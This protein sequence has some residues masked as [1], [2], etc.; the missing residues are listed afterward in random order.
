[1]ENNIPV[2]NESY[3]EEENRILHEYI[4]SASDAELVNLID[5][6]C[7]L[8]AEENKIAVKKAL[9]DFAMEIQ[10]RAAMKQKYD[11]LCRCRDEWKKYIH[12]MEDYI[13]AVRIREKYSLYKEKHENG[14]KTSFNDFYCY[15]KDETGFAGHTYEFVRICTFS[16]ESKN[17]I[18]KPEQPE[19]SYDSL[20]D[21]PIENRLDFNGS[22]EKLGTENLRC[23]LSRITASFGDSRNERAT[24]A[25]IRFMTRKYSFGSHKKKTSVPLF[26]SVIPDYLS[27][28]K[29]CSEVLAEI[30]ELKADAQGIEN[31][32][33]NN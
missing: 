9:D 1:M 21:I 10:A 24:D 22:L 32:I 15:Y 5:E 18:K 3:T 13:D 7:A 31:P 33:K 11:I 28:R 6:A 30:G 19:D 29:S 2:Y 12:Q 25:Y 8:Y 26:S 23:L 14:E 27:L 4:M 17:G 16:E 20:E